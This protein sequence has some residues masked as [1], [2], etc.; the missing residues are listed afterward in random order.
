[1]CISALFLHFHVEYRS[2]SQYT[3]YC[4]VSWYIIVSRLIGL[5]SSWYV[6]YR[7]VVADTQ[8]FV[9]QQNIITRNIMI[10]KLQILPQLLSLVLLLLRLLRRLPPRTA[11]LL[12]GDGITTRFLSLFGTFV[13]SELKFYL[14]NLHVY[15]AHSK[16]I[17]S[18]FWTNCKCFMQVVMDSYLLFHTLSITD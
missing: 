8:P 16:C 14:F 13:R 1:M 3:S 11:L 7:E 5:R 12:T 10:G 18:F 2:I 9:M 6:L 15:F 4:N 17:F